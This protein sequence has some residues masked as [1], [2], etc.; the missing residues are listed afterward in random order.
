MDF[1][2]DLWVCPVSE[3]L[4]VVALGGQGRGDF[5]SGEEWCQR[6]LKQGIGEVSERT[7]GVV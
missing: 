7:E 1:L 2:A 5:G 6:S 3:R 4:R